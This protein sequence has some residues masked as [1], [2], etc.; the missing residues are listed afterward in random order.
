MKNF[1]TFR[2]STTHRRPKDVAFERK[3]TDMSSRLTPATVVHGQC[4]KI[5][6]FLKGLEKLIYFLF[7]HQVTLSTVFYVRLS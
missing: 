3:P 2:R 5:R 1:I 7:L 4:D 6:L